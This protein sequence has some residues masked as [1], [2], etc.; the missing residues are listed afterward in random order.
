MPD[1]FSSTTTNKPALLNSVKPLFNDIMS[2]AQKYYN[3]GNYMYPKNTVAGFSNTTKDAFSGMKDLASANSDG[4]GMSS[5]LQN[6]MSN[7]GFNQGQLDSMSGIRGMADNAGLA[8]LIN[9]PNG[10]THAQN[11]AYSGLQGTV[12]RNNNAFQQTFNRG[13]LTADQN[14]V[15]DRYRAG[16]N[17]A[18]GADA[19][20]NRVKQNALDTGAQAVTAQAAKAGR[21]GGGANQ[22]ILSRN[23]M[24]TAAGMDTV[25]L[26]K[27]R[28][29]TNADAGN[30]A[31]IS[32]QGLGNQMGINSAQQSGL[33]NIGTMGNMGVGQR[34][35][36]IGTKAGLES[37]LF[38]MQNSGLANMGQAYDTAMQP[39]HTQRAVGQEWENKRQQIIDDKVNRFNQADP[40]NQLAKYLGLAS[41]A[42]VGSTQTTQQSPA[43]VAFGTG[44]GLLATLSAMRNYGQPTPGGGTGY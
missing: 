31:G 26:D 38:N 16:M 37:T 2:D 39:F 44:T 13:G 17:E 25:E 11:Q 10:M 43:Q 6:I 18:F 12:Y 28:A 4:S 35:D 23:Q 32:Q 21:F 15:A 36:A 7:G 3:K 33:Q 29:R 9:D 41:G 5:H 24:D 14:L 22:N 19:N 40:Y 1:M 34:N 42:P 8:Q 27:W 20:Y 30:L